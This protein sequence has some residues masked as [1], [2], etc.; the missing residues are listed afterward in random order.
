[1]TRFLSLLQN[2]IAKYGSIEV[3]R[4]YEDPFTVV[5]VN[6]LDG[7]FQDDDAEEVVHI[8]NTFAPSIEQELPK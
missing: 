6:G 2:H 5:D 1:V 4:L 3:E 8:I 7:V